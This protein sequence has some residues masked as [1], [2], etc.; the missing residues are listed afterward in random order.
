MRYQAVRK[1]LCSKHWQRMRNAGSLDD[2]KPPRVGC[3]FPECDEEKHFAK[4]YCEKHYTADRYSTLN[5]GIT[6]LE[7]LALMEEQGWKCAICED[8]L[9]AL[10]TTN[11]AL[12]H[13]HATGKVRGLLCHLCNKGLG[14]FRDDTDLLLSAVAYLQQR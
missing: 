12:D 8:P 6:L 9:P 13:D 14:H 4:G 7:R 5:Y 10:L 11:V 3:V 1:G 2:P